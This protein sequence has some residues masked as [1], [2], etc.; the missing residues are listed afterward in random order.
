MPALSIRMIRTALADLVIAL[1][2]GAVL[3]THKAIPIHPAIWMLFPLHIEL[4][5]YGWL[6]QFVL[7]VAYWI[8]PRFLE[9]A[10]R[11]NPLEGEVVYYALNGGILLVILSVFVP[12]GGWIKWTGRLLE[13]GAVAVFVRLHWNRVTT[14]NRS[15]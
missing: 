5:L 14:F 4:A 10:K 8:F 1:L 2:L 3:L 12:A 6:L 13:L 11:G 7:G 9:G 15:K